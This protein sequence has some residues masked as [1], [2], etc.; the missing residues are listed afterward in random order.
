MLNFKKIGFIFALSL[1]VLSVNITAFAADVP[2][3]VRVGLSSYSSKESITV[4]NNSLYIG[5]NADDNFEDIGILESSGGFTIQLPYGYYVDVRESF[6][7][8]D[9][10]WDYVTDYDD[11]GS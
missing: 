9:E 8:Y 1:S 2:D 4:S 7:T 10:A 5:A 3:M 11:Y 6:D